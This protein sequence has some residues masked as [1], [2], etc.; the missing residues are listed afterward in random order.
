MGV[1]VEL[2]ADDLR[3]RTEAD[4]IAAAS[5]IAADAWIHPYHL[6]VSPTQRSSCDHQN[7]WSLEVD[8]FQGDH[9]H[10]DE[11]RKV[12][13]SIAPHMADGATI[14][15]L[16]EGFEHW[17]IRW[18]DGRAFEEYVAEVVWAVNEEITANAQE[19]SDR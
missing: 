16:G 13:L 6:Q 3:C 4:A 9:W 8:H 7:E 18:Q 10:D 12:W 17:R 19:I 15:F 2:E 14:E 1:T 11:A 5:L